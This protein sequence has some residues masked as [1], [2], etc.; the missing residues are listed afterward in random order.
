MDDSAALR[1]RLRVELRRLRSQSTLTQRDVAKRLDWSPSKV[2]RIESG[3]VGISVTD[4]RALAALYGVTDEAQVDALVEMARGSKRQPFAEYRD[5]LPPETIRFFGYEASASLIRHVQPL[6]VPGL[7]QTEGYTRALLTAYGASGEV[8]D[9]VVESRR[10]RQEIL[11]ADG[12]P[13]V[14]TILDEG[15]VRRC[16]GGPAVMAKQLEHLQELDSRPGVSIQVMPFGAGAYEALQGAFVHLEFADP[17]DPDIVFLDN[18]RAGAVFIDD[19]AVTGTYQEKFF[20]FEESA[21]GPGQ[22]TEYAERAIK[23]FG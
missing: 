17:S 7:L 2:I 8:I 12:S 18:D 22:L 15:V 21:S 19:P 9:R 6:V 10:E 5:V 16:V 20:T 11:D 4:L 1:R 23:S 3:Q 13:E 14:F